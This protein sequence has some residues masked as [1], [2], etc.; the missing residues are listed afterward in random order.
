[1]S[2]KNKIFQDLINYRFGPLLT[3]LALDNEFTKE[4]SKRG[5]KTKIDWSKNLAGHIEKELR[6]E[7]KDMLWFLKMSNEV[8]S[9]YIEL[10]LK[11]SSLDIDTVSPKR[12][13]K[14]EN[15][16]I[17]FMKKG[18]FN[19]IHT[20]GGHISFVIYTSVPEEIKNENH[21]FK[22]NGAG[23]GSINF[24]HGET[25]EYRS[26]HS[27]VPKTGDMFLFPAKL[28]HYVPPFSSDVVRESVS[29][30]IFLY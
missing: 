8:F 30:N 3:G 11:Y 26:E 6:F 19:P 21:K 7:E 23:P 14:L 29:G 16:W 9:R 18:E 25:S 5:K 2:L 22:G 1:M 28:R 12:S 10:Y 15:L 13:Y 27:F 20:H 17:N 4:L 24:I